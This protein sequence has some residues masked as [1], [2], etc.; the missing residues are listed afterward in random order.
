LLPCGADS[1]NRDR[2]NFLQAIKLRELNTT[3]K[4]EKID[5]KAIEL[6]AWLRP[7]FSK[8]ARADSLLRE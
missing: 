1:P 6:R 2:E 8:L 7:Q 4:D 3:P 5:F